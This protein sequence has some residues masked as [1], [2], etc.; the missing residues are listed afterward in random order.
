M[1]ATEK[2]VRKVVDH[3]R[4]V[5]HPSFSLSG[6]ERNQLFLNIDKDHFRSVS[7]LSGA[8]D[9]SDGRAM[10]RLDFDRDGYLD[11]A[12]AN[13]NNP[14][15]MLFRNE[16]GE[17]VPDLKNHHMVAIRLVGGN[18]LA[19]P[20]DTL[21][22]RDGIG[23]RVWVTTATDKQVQEKHAGEG[24]AAQNSDL[25]HF[26]LGQSDSIQ[27]LT[28]RW[29]S[30]RTQTFHDLPADSLVTL[31]EE[32]S[33]SPA[34]KNLT[35]APYQ[36]A[37]TTPA[38]PGAKLA[39][40]HFSTTP[41]Q[42]STLR[43]YLGM[44]TTCPSCNAELAHLQR[45]RSLFQDSELEMIAIPLDEHD[46]EKELASYRDS[47]DLPYQFSNAPLQEARTAMVDLVREHL[48]QFSYPVSVVT[49]QDNEVLLVTWGTPTLSKLRQLLAE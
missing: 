37:P 26:G 14:L 33:Q 28:I 47:H 38:V 11:F 16:L 15:F 12:V 22:N 17:N 8:N 35:T 13:A 34:G 31:F 27:E 18:Q 24:F 5:E 43:L 4:Q 2:V 41:P 46:G 21:S 10:V 48:Y 19:Q 7:A 44:A 36:M 3:F 39:K 40:P 29:P 1:V 45:L 20:S 42:A 30:G 25:L 49:N 32:A 6:N 23:A 9:P